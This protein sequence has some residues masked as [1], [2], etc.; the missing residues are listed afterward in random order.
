MTI[1][2]FSTKSDK[3]KIS[4]E[5]TN[6]KIVTGY[7]KNQFDNGSPV[8]VLELTDDLNILDYNYCHIDIN[9]RYYFIQTKTFTQKN[10]CVLQLEIDLLMTYKNQILNSQIRASAGNA[11]NQW[12]MRS[13]ALDTNTLKR[14]DFENPFV[15]VDGK[16]IMIAVNGV[17][18]ISI[19]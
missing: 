10:I 18:S 13:E 14:I 3:R 17:P 12:K 5:L 16:N 1:T 2:L 8:I 9:N 7:C 4:K 6:E 15:G 11:V 19:Q